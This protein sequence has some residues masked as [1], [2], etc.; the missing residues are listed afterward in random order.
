MFYRSILEKLSQWTEKPTRKPLVLRGARQVGKTTVVKILSSQFKYFVSLNLDVP[1]NRK[2][3]EKELSIHELVQA[4]FFIHQIPL[5]ETERTLIFIDE[6]QNSPEAIGMLRYFYEEVPRLA[7]I[8]AGSLL[9]SLFDV[10]IS[11]PVG[12]VEYLMMH[13]CSFEEFLVALGEEEAYELVKA[14]E[15]PVYAHEKLLKLFHHYTMMGGMPEI[16]SA[17]ASSKDLVAL[18]SIY[19]SLLVG[20]MDDVEKYAS[21]KNQA[22][23]IRHLIRN[24]PLEAG[25]RIKFEGFG[26]SNYSSRDVG[27]AFR[28]LEKTMLLRLIYPLSNTDAP[29]MPNLK[30]SPRLQFLD[31]GLVNYFS[32]IQQE[33][34]ALA[35]LNNLY[36]GRIAEHMVGQLL[37]AM[38]TSPL[39]SLLFWARDKAQSNAEVDFI[40][41]F[42]KSLVPVEVK[43][44]KTGT[45]RSLHQFMDDVSHDFAIRLFAGSLQED[46]VMTPNQKRYRLISCP[47]YLAG[48][49]PL[50]IERYFS[51]G[52]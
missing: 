42:E 11:F 21:T 8:C 18:G 29:F 36:R 32:G 23:I 37:M 2:L 25:S 30:K 40:V 35:D 14:G 48:S 4:I 5:V 12:R 6:I 44:G 9:E 17:Y 26:H 16:V 1:E 13:P 7:V 20:Y 19:E 50:I 38:Q 43:S 33:F 51:K 15:P 47:Y 22:M 10:E 46:Y 24:G 49:L 3:F 45:L 27:E 28:I 41:P 31:T 39:S 52:L 34:F